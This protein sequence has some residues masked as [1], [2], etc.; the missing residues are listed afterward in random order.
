MSRVA[1]AVFAQNAG[2]PLLVIRVLRERGDDNERQVAPYGFCLAGR[3]GA[4]SAP[5]LC[6]LSFFCRFPNLVAG[7]RTMR[8]SWAPITSSSAIPRVCRAEPL[9]HSAA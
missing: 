4:D 5:G 9:V 8:R 3:F 7:F 1:V 6:L 2:R